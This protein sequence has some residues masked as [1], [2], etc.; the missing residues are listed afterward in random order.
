MAAAV[1]LA[2]AMDQRTLI[3]LLLRREGFAHS[4]IRVGGLLGCGAVAALIE[5]GAMAALRMLL[6]VKYIEL[7]LKA[8]FGFV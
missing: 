7:A 6:M 4:W 8:S 5:T 3:A 1:A 2:L